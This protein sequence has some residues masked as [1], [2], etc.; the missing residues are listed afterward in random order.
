MC[1]LNQKV[2]LNSLLQLVAASLK[3]VLKHPRG[4]RLF[5][6]V[7]RKGDQKVQSEGYQM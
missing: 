7:T 2:V 6:R 5:V 1:T 4:L 3:Q